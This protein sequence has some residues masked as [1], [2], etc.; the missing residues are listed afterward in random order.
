MSSLRSQFQR[1]EGALLERTRVAHRPIMSVRVASARAGVSDVTWRSYTNGYRFLNPG[2]PIETIAPATTLSRMA[3]AVGLAPADLESAGRADAAFVLGGG[4][5]DD[6]DPSL[7]PKPSTKHT[8]KPFVP[9]PALELIES[10]RRTAK[11]TIPI[12]K[13]ATAARISYTQWRNLTLGR[14]QLGQRVQTRATDAVVARMA[15]A[16]NVSPEEIASRGRPAAAALMAAAETEHSANDTLERHWARLARERHVSAEELNDLGDDIYNAVNL[17]C[18]YLP[19]HDER[20]EL[21]SRLLCGNHRLRRI[22]NYLEGLNVAPS[23]NA[24]SRG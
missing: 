1:P 7:T 20:Q 9:D 15:H 2:D 16:V 10:R 4:N 14:P 12:R 21:I 19:K 3:A 24:R 17:L 18:V 22:A 11:P 8:P 23:R 5:P 6:L 13:A